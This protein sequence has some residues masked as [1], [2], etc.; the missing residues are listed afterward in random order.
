MACLP[1]ALIVFLGNP[2]LEVHEVVPAFRDSIVMN[3]ID[4]A[5][6]LISPDAFDQV[7]SVL[8]HHPDQAAAVFQLAGVS[9]D[10]DTL[11]G[12]S[13]REVVAA[14]LST[15]SVRGAV[16]LF[17]VTVE[18]PVTRRNGTFVPVS[19]GLPGARDTV[20]LELVL[21]D[22]RWRIRDFFETLP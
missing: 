14:V 4:G 8:V 19:F 1:L 16:M 7:D 9:M 18:D 10:V 12:R 11:C 2:S 15:P 13:G 22:D 3:S 6:A 20:Y 5:L 21:E 17:G